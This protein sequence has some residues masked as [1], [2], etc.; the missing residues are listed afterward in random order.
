LT[1]KQIK[2]KNSY[3]ADCGFDFLVGET[4]DP[5][6]LKSTGTSKHE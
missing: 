3:L 5:V 4:C 1:N 2:T 6:K